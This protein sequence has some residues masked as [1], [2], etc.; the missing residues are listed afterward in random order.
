MQENHER[1][2]TAMRKSIADVKA[3][4]LHACRIIPAMLCFTPA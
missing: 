1:E 2:M 3:H 4:A